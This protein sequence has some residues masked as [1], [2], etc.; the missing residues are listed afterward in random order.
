M[1]ITPLSASRHGNIR[2]GPRPDAAYGARHNH[3]VLGASEI[4]LASADYPIFLMKDGETGAF[5]IVA[6]FGFA[7]GQ[8]GFVING[9]WQATWIPGTM[10][11]YPFYRDAAAPHGLA[12][13]EDC[14]L[15]HADQG[16]ALFADGQATRYTT[17]IAQTISELVDDV[18]AAQALARTLAT[19]ALVRP[20][21][22]I[23]TDAAGH[24]NQ[25]DGL[26]GI[27]LQALD[28]LDDRTV[29]SLHRQG[30]LR[31]A[32]VMAGSLSQLER[33]RQLH[34]YASAQPLASM[35]YAIAD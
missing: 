20:L 17:H 8:N 9:S 4:M 2:I 18:A 26:Y 16:E 7:P 27:S 24:E 15:L 35:V 6:L 11:R 10:L 22:L 32:D 31:A 30:A 34:D 23:L 3:A 14:G 5:S 13:D 1:G 28:E 25:I 21:T 33:V 19:N 29:L 12:I